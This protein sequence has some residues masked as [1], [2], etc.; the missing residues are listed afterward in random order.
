MR[1]DFFFDGLG[2]DVVAGI[3]NDQIFQPSADAPVAAGVGRALIAGM[4]PSVAQGARG[5]LR[6]IP[7]ARENIRAAHHD[8][9]V[10]RDFHFKAGDRWTDVAGFDGRARVVHGAD[11]GGF[12]QAVDLQNWDLQHFKKFLRFLRKRRGAAD[13]R[14][15]MR[16]ET[17]FYLIEDSA[18]ADQQPETIQNRAFAAALSLPRRAGTAEQPLNGGGSLCKRGVYAAFDAFEQRGNVEKIVRRCQSNF[19]DEAVEVGGESDGAVSRQEGEQ[20]NPRCAKIERQ[21]MEDTVGLLR[22]RAARELT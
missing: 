2:R 16:A 4:K 11:A 18:A 14:A 22:W 3:E 5:F 6:A 12:G 8:F 9:V 7:V 10:L 19:V 1:R 20:R 13:Q 21:I 17:R 15:E